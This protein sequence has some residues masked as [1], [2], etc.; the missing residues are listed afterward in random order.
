MAKDLIILGAGGAGMDIVEMVLA[1][2][3]ISETWR[4]VGFLDDNPELIDREFLGVP[5][6][7]GIDLAKSFTDAYF[8]SSIGYPDR[9][10]IR[11]EV[12]ERIPFGNE[13][14]AT[15]VHPTAVVYQSARILPGCVIGSGCQ[16]GSLVQIG[17]NVGV[18]YESII[19][20]E[21]KIG[22]HTALASGVILS[23]DVQVGNC[24]Y[25]GAGA[26]VTHSVSIGDNTLI[27]IGSIVTK[28]VPSNI[29]FLN[30]VRPFYIPD[31]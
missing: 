14:F 19:A 16:I 2:N 31:G 9:R 28:S 11:K 15:I 10:Y 30:D 24:T 1:V 23:S 22:D 26:V 3:R 27:S 12:R 18:A 5:V 29:K 8:I 20:H 25:I 13:R 7:G 17:H 21:C 6:L 4:T